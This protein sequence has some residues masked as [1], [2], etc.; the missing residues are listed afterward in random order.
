MLLGLVSSLGY[1]LRAALREPTG[2][3]SQ[4]LYSLSMLGVGYGGSK[5]YRFVKEGGVAKLKLNPRA[6]LF[7][8]LGASLNTVAKL[9]GAPLAL[10]RSY[11]R[12]LLLKLDPT[13]EKDEGAT[14]GWKDVPKPGLGKLAPKPPKPPWQRA[15]DGPSGSGGG[16][17][18]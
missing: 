12:A 8:A 4:V 15:A 10:L 6:V 18:E 1:L 17:G 13:L 11:L 14:L 9:L 7:G 5:G 16:S 2:G 3:A